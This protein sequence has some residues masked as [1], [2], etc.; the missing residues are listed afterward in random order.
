MDRKEIE[1][2]MKDVFTSHEA[3]EYLGISTQRLNKMVHDGLI[4]PIKS[5]KSVLLFYKN[6]L[7]KRTRLD[8]S[9][10]KDE[11]TTFDIES[12]SVKDAVIYFSVQHFFKGSDKATTDFFKRVFH[13]E[14]GNE[15]DK[16]SL[17]E[18]S[19]WLDVDFVTFKNVYNGVL[20]S[21]KALPKDTILIK[22]GDLKYSN[23]LNNT[24]EAPQYLFARGDIELLNERSVSVV[25]SRNASAKGLYDTERFV[26]SLVKRNIVIVAGL[27]KGIDYQAHKSALDAGGKTIAVIGTPINQYYPKENRELQEEIAEKGLLISQFSPYEKTERWHFPVRNATMSGI[28]TATV[29]MEAGETSGALIQA[30]YAIKQDKIV[31]IPSSAVNNQN[32]KWPKKYIEKGAMEFSTLKEA[33]SMLQQS[34]E[35]NQL[36]QNSEELDSV[37]MD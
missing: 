9:F 3:A 5:S 4:T 27:A 28:S 12:N 25:G 29:I 1:E 34:K 30:D 23:L 16:I 17:E 20:K 10:L 14:K 15:K 8:S 11:Q 32:I 35:L 7:D 31:L 22:K 26:N 18:L 37:Q 24:N 21:F 13:L 33:L 19:K 2:I 6:D 36:L